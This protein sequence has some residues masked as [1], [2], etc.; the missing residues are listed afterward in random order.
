MQPQQLKHMEKR[1]GK[2]G[3]VRQLE[4]KELQVKAA[5]EVLDNKLTRVKVSNKNH[6]QMSAKLRILQEIKQYFLNQIYH[7]AKEGGIPSQARWRL[8]NLL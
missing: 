3:M 4:E 7:R 1:S 2:N 6:L 5:L 8:P